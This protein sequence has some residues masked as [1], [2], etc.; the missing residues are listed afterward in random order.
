MFNYFGT[1]NKPT[2][3]NKTLTCSFLEP[4]PK[5]NVVLLKS[6]YIDIYR[7]N[8]DS[9]LELVLSHNM[10]GNIIILEKIVEEKAKKADNLFILSESLDYCILKY[11]K[12][13]SEIKITAKGDIREGFC[14]IKSNV[15]YSID[16]NYKFIIISPY[17]NIIRVIFLHSEDREKM[18]DFKIQMNYDDLLYLFHLNKNFPSKDLE[19]FLCDKSNCDAKS[20]FSF[21][22]KNFEK[23]IKN[24]SG[25]RINTNPGNKHLFQVIKNED[26]LLKATEKKTNISYYNNS[27]TQ[28]IKNN[29]SSE[30]FAMV[31]INNQYNIAGKHGRDSNSNSSN[32]EEKQVITLEPFLIDFQNKEIKKVFK[33]S[34]EL[35]SFKD[36]NFMFSPKIGGVVVFYSDDIEYFEI[37]SNKI[38]KCPA[39][40]K[41][42]YLKTPFPT[43]KDYCAIDL[44]NYILYDTEGGMYLFN[45]NICDKNNLDFNIN[46]ILSN[47]TN[48]NQYEL[49]LIPLG[50]VNYISSLSYLENNLFFVG[51]QTSNS[52]YIKL[53]P[54]DSNN[55]KSLPHS[56]EIKS[57]QHKANFDSHSENNTNNDNN[58][59]KQDRKINLIEVI[60][61][62]E[63]LG[64]ISDFLVLND[65][66][67]ADDFT[68][69]NTEILCVCGIG[70]Y[71][72][73]KSIRKGWNYVEDTQ[74][75]FISSNN[76]FSVEVT[77]DQSTKDTYD[78][79]QYLHPDYM[80][81][82]GSNHMVLDYNRGY[83][84]NYM[85]DKNNNCFANVNDYAKNN[86][87]GSGNSSP[88]SLKKKNVLM[89][90]WYK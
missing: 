69:I 46:L 61:E 53:N 45:I 10:F 51:S 14:K 62:Y 26:L 36:S 74:I 52:F 75:P 5:L 80:H 87:E 88:S 89:F 81:S 31:K 84:T 12:E 86:Y 35:D 6:N 58:N 68:D 4:Y 28:N 78:D 1:I 66:K 50:E 25:Y 34:F 19:S 71:S 33:I 77:L 3:I 17:K 29:Y 55:Y 60:E 7:K 67:N 72:C 73:F 85:S 2:A 21:D 54:F 49:Y 59:N 39:L 82:S 23:S 65:A 57:I 63:N 37:L 44:V 20:P 30:L 15:L 43:F 40:I 11:D 38:Q 64:P 32:P 18:Q 27:K 83:D 90:L 8:N 56:N 76:F 13:K 79:P 42:N 24:L 48:Q 22:F 16:K 47:K 9:H 70:K 41:K